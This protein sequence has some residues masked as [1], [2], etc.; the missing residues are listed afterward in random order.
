MKKSLIPI[1]LIFA[2]LAGCKGKGNNNGT[3]DTA[4]GGTKSSGGPV[5]S[6]GVGGQPTM[7]LT[8]PSVVGGQAG[9]ISVTAPANTRILISAV[10]FGTDQTQ[11]VTIW[12]GQ[13]STT[14]TPLTTLSFSSNW[15]SFVTPN[16]SVNTQTFTITDS[17]ASAPY[18][19]C[20]SS[21]TASGN[22]ALGFDITTYS[23]NPPAKGQQ[24]N[25][26]VIAI[27]DLC[28]QF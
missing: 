14:G 28:G 9:S 5:T 26:S 3:A 18:S 27:V 20:G 25:K 15:A 13:P 11:K 21:P 1:L 7:I 10:F 23:G 4:S 6:T 19:N 2:L 22:N 17:L 12:N 8:P 24:I 16:D